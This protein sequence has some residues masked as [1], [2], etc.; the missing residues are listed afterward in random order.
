MLSDLDGFLTGIAVGPELVLPSEWL[1]LIWR[2]E[3]PEFAD[4]AEAKA[5]LGAIM[6]RY[7]EILRQIADNDLDPVFWVDRDGTLIAADWAE[8]FLQAIMLR[9]DAWGRL[10]KSKRDGHLLFPILALC[11]DENGESLLG[12]ALGRGRTRDG[13]DDR[14]HPRLRHRHRRLLART[15][16]EA[17]LDAAHGRWRLPA[18]PNFAQGRP[19]RALSLRLGQQVQE[20]LRPMSGSTNITRSLWSS[21]DDYTGP[22]LQIISREG[23]H[24][25]VTGSEHRSDPGCPK[26]S[27]L[28]LAM[29]IKEV[30]RQLTK[31]RLILVSFRKNS[32]LIAHWPIDMQSRIVP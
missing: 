20:V 10:F 16:I 23:S 22:L 24:W 21:P 13:G 7:N 26:L 11:G 31:L 14:I 32:R 6:A 17:S 1:P 29:T 3:A 18:R 5:I 2:G 15:G 27:R 9:A 28:I 12:L 19:Q 30:C 4:E 25:T 8:G